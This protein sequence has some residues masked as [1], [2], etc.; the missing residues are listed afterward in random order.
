MNPDKVKLVM[1][2]M[3]GPVICKISID[4]LNGE[5]QTILMNM[6]ILSSGSYYLHLDDTSE[7]VS[8]VLVIQE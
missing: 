6:S 3:K 1:T 4:G 7:R 2:D 5:G 8:K